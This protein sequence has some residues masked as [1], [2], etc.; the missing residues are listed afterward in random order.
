MKDNSLS[1]SLSIAI[2][3]CCVV[4]SLGFA[5]ERELL[6]VRTFTGHIDGI[7]A[8]DVSSEGTRLLTSS[9]DHTIRRWNVQ[10]GEEIQ[11]Y[12]IGT[13]MTSITLSP[14][15]N[16]FVAG[17][18]TGVVRMWNVESGDMLWE[19]DA[20]SG[21]VTDTAYSPNGEILITGAKQ[22]DG[23]A[24]LW[25]ANTGNN[26]LSFTAHKREVRSVAFSPDGTKALTGGGTGYPDY[27]GD[28]KL[29]EVETGT[30]VASF[31]SQS[32]Y[33]SEAVFTPDGTGILIAPDYVLTREGSLIHIARLFNVEKG[34]TVRTFPANPTAS[35]GTA[36]SNEIASMDV[37]PD[38]S[39]LVTGGLDKTIKLWNMHTGEILCAFR[40][41]DHYVNSVLFSPD[42]KSIFSCSEDGTAK[43]WNIVN[44]PPT[45]TPTVLPT[46]TPTPPTFPPIDPANL[47]TTSSDF[48]I[49]DARELPSSISI[50][51]ERIV[52]DLQPGKD[53]VL[54]ASHHVTIARNSKGNEVIVLMSLEEKSRIVAEI[55]PNTFG[56]T[57]ILGFAQDVLLVRL[58]RYPE[59]DILVRITG[60]WNVDTPASASPPTVDLNRDGK[61]DSKDLLRFQGS[62]RR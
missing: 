5:Q 59:E 53:I 6:L 43:L 28:A 44:I 50:E 18:K 7:T 4:T 32:D 24:K 55:S 19:I 27:E 47:I 51:N 26:L 40:A 58:N 36:H 21:P 3:S 54:D 29:W 25:E 9:L 12:T 45:P 60:D 13:E 33:V 62:W 42:G 17:A 1:T 23:T 41:H 22:F 15:D 52:L 46:P 16:D 35:Q 57:K 8:F 14:D 48:R 10:T 61:V 2:L 38:G 39:M 34:E 49:V 11:T 37:S 56:E 30:V 20:H 31:P